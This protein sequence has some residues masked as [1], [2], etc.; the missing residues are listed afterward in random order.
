MTPTLLFA[1]A[2]LTGP[3][4]PDADCG[5]RAQA[6]QV[7]PPGLTPT[8]DP[9]GGPP[10]TA[11]QSPPTSPPPPPPTTRTEP[12]YVPTVDPPID[13][14]PPEPPYVPTVD[15][16]IDPEPEPPYVPE[17]GEASIEIEWS[18]EQ[19]PVVIGDLVRGSIVV[20]CDAGGAEVGY[21][22]RCVETTLLDCTPVEG[23]PWGPIT[24][25][26]FSGTSGAISYLAMRA[27][28][29]ETK[30]E[31]D[32][33]GETVE[34]QTSLNVLP[35]DKIELEG[36]GDST[37]GASMSVTIRFHYT[38]AG[39]DLGIHYQPTAQEEIMPQVSGPDPPEYE[40]DGGWGPTP[41]APPCG[42]AEAPNYLPTFCYTPSYISDAKWRP[43]TSDEFKN[44]EVGDVFNRIKQR[45]RIDSAHCCFLP[46]GL[47]E[48]RYFIIES[49]KA[50]DDTF[51]IRLAPDGT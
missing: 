33:G 41:G 39:R 29:F 45:V 27:G 32:C 22:T 28:K 8:P 9:I 10:E 25:D 44:A 42:R 17:P 13:P 38:A 15:P 35:P 6:G 37:A 34:D 47:W 5:C 50:S 24:K 12:P 3:A 36:L 26:P 2:L 4:L 23:V 14:E 30:A 31:M 40:W 11:P 49:A 21:V 19:E 7:R 1:A 16:P 51:T 48:S 46:E 43:S 18:P 20:G